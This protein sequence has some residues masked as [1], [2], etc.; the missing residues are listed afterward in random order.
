LVLAIDPQHT[1]TLERL[2][3]LHAAQTTG[4]ERLQKRPGL[5]YPSAAAEAAAATVVEPEPTQAAPASEPDLPLE[6][7]ELNQVIDSRLR[8]QLPAHSSGIYE[9]HLDEVEET[10]AVEF[11]QAQIEPAAER[12]GAAVGSERARDTATRLLPRTPLFSE[13]S[14]DSLVRLVNRVSLQELSAGEYVFRAGDPAD[15]LY[16][17]VEGAVEAVKEGATPVEQTRLAE[18]E[19]FG[20][21]GLLS[22]SPRQRTVVALEETQL[23]VIDRSVVGELRG[24]EP[25]FLKVLL[26]FLRCRLIAPLLRHSPLF[27]PFSDQE[28]RAM[29]KKFQFLELEAG[30]VLIEEGKRAD[31]LFVLLSG[32]AEVIRGTDELLAVLRPGDV[33]GEM[34]LLT[35]NPAVGTVRA[36]QKA[37]ALEMPAA[38]FT[39]TVMV[40]PQVLMYVSE[41]ADQRRRQNE[42]AADERL[43]FS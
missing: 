7:I 43:S 38:R 29:T 23:L 21:I 32:E 34:S 4:L 9:L 6:A 8:S 2:A 42:V 14:G 20:E 41:L 16:V 17:V 25:A 36:K 5:T 33:F 10:Q 24:A 18:G 27:A 22:D 37:F 12:A 3:K 19:F 31:G 30:A 26:R 13:L 11:D 35:G 15:A 39:E 28:Q 40:H 1:D